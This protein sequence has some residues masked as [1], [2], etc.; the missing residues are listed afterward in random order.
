VL[1]W[2]TQAGHGQE[3]WASGGTPATTRLV[4]EIGPGAASGVS[5][6][7]YGA[8]QIVQTGAGPGAKLIFIADDGTGNNPWA[9]GIGAFTGELRWLPVLRR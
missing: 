9:V 1:L 4:Q 8:Q 3:L 7:T 6:R 5:W 2:A